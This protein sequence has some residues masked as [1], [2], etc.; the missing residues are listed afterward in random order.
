M[1]VSF[2]TVPPPSYIPFCSRL[3]LPSIRDYHRLPTRAEAHALCESMLAFIFNNRGNRTETAH[4]TGVFPNDLPDGMLRQFRSAPPNNLESV[5]RR[6][7]FLADFFILGTVLAGSVN[8]VNIPKLTIE[9]DEM[10]RV[11]GAIKKFLDSPHLNNNTKKAILHFFCGVAGIADAE[12]LYK[13]IKSMPEWT[14]FWQIQ[15]NRRDGVPVQARDNFAVVPMCES[16]GSNYTLNVAA[17][18]NQQSGSGPS[19]SWSY[20][21]PSNSVHTLNNR[22]T[23]YIPHHV[24]VVAGTGADSTRTGNNYAD[25]SLLRIPSIFDIYKAVSHWANKEDWIRHLTGAPAERIF[26]TNEYEIM[27]VR[28]NTSKLI[29]RHHEKVDIAFDN[30]ETFE[31][32]DGQ[33]PFENHLQYIEQIGW[34]EHMSEVLASHHLS[35]DEFINLLRT[36]EHMHLFSAEGLALC[37]NSQL[38]TAFFPRTVAEENA[39]PDPSAIEPARPATPEEFVET[40][41]DSPF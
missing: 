37:R 27:D 7:A 29:Q 30:F 19:H 39:V 16:Q 14:K 40:A 28:G 2:T 33:S 13:Y 5:I 26:I 21:N 1:P 38:W 4:I 41:T 17:I 12:M 24:P 20:V 23:S 10:K 11:F 15:S 35:E 18:V 34:S 6:T 3:L 32:F 9:G 8:K 22:R 36:G 31:E 25:S